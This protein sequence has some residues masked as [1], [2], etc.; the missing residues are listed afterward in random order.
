METE[1][2]GIYAM[3]EGSG[4][5]HSLSQASACGVM[6]ARVLLEKYGCVPEE[7]EEK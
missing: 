7:T 6:T 3:G 5:T 2:K 1:V 4:V